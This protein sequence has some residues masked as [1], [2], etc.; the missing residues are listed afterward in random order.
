MR[1]SS[2]FGLVRNTG[3]ELELKI[4]N[5][6]ERGS[7]WMDLCNGFLLEED[8]EKLLEYDE[9]TAQGLLISILLA[10]GEV[11]DEAEELRSNYCSLLANL[12]II[13]QLSTRVLDQTREMPQGCP[14]R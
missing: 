6:F 10:R 13:L 9:R 3:K 14:N 4:R 2:A 12:F 8:I 1:K 7:A 11:E 5:L